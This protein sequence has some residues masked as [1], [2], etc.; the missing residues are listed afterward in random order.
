MCLLCVSVLPLDQ[1][2]CAIRG[3]SMI[4]ISLVQL[5]KSGLMKAVP[6]S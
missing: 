5:T 2:E 3:R 4:S 6:R 1:G